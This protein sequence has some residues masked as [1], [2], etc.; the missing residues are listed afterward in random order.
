MK[1]TW[2]DWLALWVAVAGFYPLV[3]AGHHGGSLLSLLD[4]ALHLGASVLLMSRWTVARRPAG[5][6]A[7]YFQER[8]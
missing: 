7:I 5:R 4:I 8:P 6:T 1:A 3:D 2:V